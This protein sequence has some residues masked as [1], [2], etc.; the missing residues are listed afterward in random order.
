VTRSTKALVLV[1]A[2]AVFASSC[3]GGS[4]STADTTTADTTASPSDTSAEEDRDRNV[5]AAGFGENGG[6][7][8]G[9]RVAD[10]AETLFETR[11]FRRTRFENADG[12]KVANFR[13]VFVV[14]RVTRTIGN[15]ITTTLHVDGYTTEGDDPK[16]Y[17]MTDFGNNGRV[18]IEI[19]EE[20]GEW[21]N[22]PNGFTVVSRELLAV[23]F[24]SSTEDADGAG[25]IKFYDLPS[26]QPN[27]MLGD[28]GR[29]VVPKSAGIT[30]VYDIAFRKMGDDGMP[31]LV[32]AGLAYGE[33]DDQYTEDDVAIAGV[34]ADGKL[35]PAV[36]V[37]GSGT[38]S[39]R[40]S[41]PSFGTNANWYIRLA[42]PGLSS[43]PGVVGAVLTSWIPAPERKTDWWEADE[44]ELTG[45]VARAPR[46]GG[47]ITMDAANGAYANAFVTGL[48]S[49][50][51]RNAIIDIDGSLDAHI[52][53]IP[54]GTGYAELEEYGN[55]VITF[56]S[57]SPTAGV[58][59]RSIFA[60]FRTATDSLVRVGQFVN[61]LS[62][63][64]KGFAVE[65]YH[66][67]VERTTSSVICF[68][69]QVCNIPALSGMR[70]VIDMAANEGAWTS[71]ESMKVDAEGIHIVLKTVGAF[72]G[73]APHSV[74]SFPVDG[75]AVA[76]DPTLFRGDF[77]FYQDEEVEENGEMSSV[78][79]RWI[80]P[81]KVM[82]T[83]RLATFG[84]TQRNFAPNT[85]LVSDAGEE[86]REIPLSLP[87]GVSQY[88]ADNGDVTEIDETSLLLR[89]DLW[90]DEGTEVRLYKVNVD[91]GSVDVGFGDKGHASLPALRRDDDCRWKEVL[92]SGP[93][94]VGLLVIDH[95]PLTVDD[96]ED[97]SETPQT[98]S[99]TT[100]TTTGQPVGAG[101][102]VADL[103]PL[104]LTRA[105]DYMI[106]ARG[107]LYVVGYKDVYDG[108][109]YVTANATVAKFT[110]AGKLDATFG[111]QG[112]VTFD[113]KTNALHSAGV[114][115]VG[116]IDAQER[117][118]LA[119][120]LTDD[121]WNTDVL[122]M[123]LSAA[124]AVDASAIAVA[125]E[126]TVPGDAG[127]TPQQEREAAEKQRKPLAAEAAEERKSEEREA[128]LP[129][130]NGLTVTATKPLITAVKADKDRSL[131]V[132]WTQSIAQR[133]FVTATAT[134]GG[135]MCTSDQGSCIIRGL[136]PSVSY[137]VTVAPKGAEATASVPSQ[138]IKPVVTLKAGRVASPTTYVRPASKGKATWK[139][140]G[141]CTLNASNT[142][143]TAP[144]RAATCVLSVTTAK[145]G[146]TP[147]TTKSVTIVVPK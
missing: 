4:D 44:I 46:T 32:V 94:V 145:F 131:T 52:S 86:P 47:P 106:D 74:V 139:V 11:V 34:T 48:E 141:G 64:G 123:R 83:R 53:G 115:M 121:R 38:I 12:R 91:N 113:G 128:A 99:W 31:H 43:T 62:T 50:N 39:L 41:L 122:V 1:C 120:P 134:P 61:D 78:N 85:L 8:A 130:D 58:A 40:E 119:A 75:S 138:G 126:D 20:S 114:T 124:G 92:D 42:D 57:S 3:G 135:R 69:G 132:W 29:I 140:R 103:A 36:G 84:S 117:V 146:P 87:L 5:G 125:P 98:V 37:G 65:L 143:V 63:E 19:K 66:D 59:R 129:I 51:L 9:A 17:P 21:W 108:D 137:T 71:L 28:K 111:T 90:S 97:C 7:I 93:G 116:A 27:T 15:S 55:E 68:D 70:E 81:P 96:P 105:V 101:T 127:T 26:G 109:E 45:I 54:F 79:L 95:D 14:T 73:D 107:N 82:S 16:K 35:D 24:P 60:Q 23:S 147:K 30:D 133:G 104:A 88:S 18:T 49:V 89:A 142:R 10:R 72:S 25:L 76:G 13:D 102:S 22:R 144:K 80:A 118:Y 77:D 56:T 112:V 110:S 136:D 2:T 67:L 100:V 33:N 6:G